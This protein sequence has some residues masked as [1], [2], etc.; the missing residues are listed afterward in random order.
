MPRS[1]ASTGLRRFRRFAQG[2]TGRPSVNGGPSSRRPCVKVAN[3]RCLLLLPLDS[4][5]DTL[6]CRMKRI[7]LSASIDRAVGVPE[8]AF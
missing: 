5:H 3:I 1:V 4:G 2:Q 6:L 8:E 7:R